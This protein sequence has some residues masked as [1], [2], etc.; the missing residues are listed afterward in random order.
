[1]SKGDLLTLIR[2]NKE[3]T[4]EVMTDMIR[5]AAA[6]MSYLHSVNIIHR[7]L[8]LRNL[9]VTSSDNKYTI[10]VADVSKNGLL[11]LIFFSLD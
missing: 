11:F 4:V 3:I 6:G 1:M 8:A 7:D 9:L 2:S 5:Q 10:K